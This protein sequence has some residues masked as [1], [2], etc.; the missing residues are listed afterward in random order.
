MFAPNFRITPLIMQALM[1]IE[2]DRQAVNDLPFDVEMLAALRETARLIAT[3]RSTQIEGNR[4]TQME[5]QETLSGARFPGRERDE[6]EVRH[7][8]RA[9]EDVEQLAQMPGGT[10]EASLQ[11]LHS[12][13]LHGRTSPTPYRD[14]QNVIRDSLS[15]DIVYL[16]PEAKDVPLLMAELIVWLNGELERAELPVPIIAALTHYQFATIH[17][18][19]DGNGRTARLLTTL[20]LHKAGYGLKGLYSLEEYYARNING[21]Y[22]ALVVGASHNYYLGRVEADVTGFV[23]Y[24][25]QGMAEAFSA[26]RVQAASASRRGALD[27]SPLLRRLDPRQRLL[28]ALFRTR[29]IVTT[30]EIAAHLHLSPRTVVALCREWVAV[31]FLVL[32][33]P[34]RKNRS[35]SLTPAYETLVAETVE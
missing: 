25:C 7:Y 11:R 14:G 28:L 5:V 17:P 15:S 2:A 26:V 1:S 32:H 22:Q 33:D 6:R 31:G 16:P 19:Y 23:D 9:I 3:H 13:V 20:I 21:Y 34:S 29:A 8:Y 27:R 35:Y 18:Y 24:F 30:A 4:L 10:T 12:R